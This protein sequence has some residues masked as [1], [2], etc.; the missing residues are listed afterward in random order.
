MAALQRTGLPLTA[1]VGVVAPED[2]G[3]RDLLSRAC[4][5]DAMPTVVWVDSRTQA[6]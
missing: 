4:V 1:A 3:R 6:Q 2:R 5:E